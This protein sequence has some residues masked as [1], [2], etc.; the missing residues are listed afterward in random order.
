VAFLVDVACWLPETVVVNDDFVQFPAQYRAMIA[1]KAG[2][3]ARRRVTTE[4]TSDVG[5]QAVALLLKKTGLDPD[6]VGALICAT[7]SPDRMQP[8]T[9]TSIQHACGLSRA[10]AFDLNAVCSGAVYALRVAAGLVNEGVPNVIVVG[11]E[12]YSRILNPKDITTLPYFGDGAGAA[13]VAAE[14]AYEMREWI[15]GSD[16]SGADVIQVPGGG[17]KLPSPLVQREK[18]HYFTMNGAAVFEF[19]CRQ[20]SAVLRELVQRSGGVPD[21][22]VTHQANVRIIDEIARLSG[23]PRERFVV[24]VDRYGNTAAAS[25]LIGLAEHLE[26]GAAPRSIMLV[27]FG[28]GLAWAGCEL[29]L[30]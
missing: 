28:G 2:I 3:L 5:A 9:A 4:C 17:T 15:L 14:G 25:V 18:D 11:A 8:P 16:G 29:R 21:C 6:A 1:E 30:R 10:F 7:S 19:A 12:V 22:V 26:S 13:L 27:G 20:G 23:V 24:N